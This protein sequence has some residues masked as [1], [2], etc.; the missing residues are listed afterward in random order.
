MGGGSLWKMFLTLVTLVPDGEVSASKDLLIFF[1]VCMLQARMKSMLALD[2]KARPGTC[3][4]CAAGDSV[5]TVTG[6]VD[7]DSRVLQ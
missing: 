4:V 7:A 3:T 5:T 1:G 6:C 2:A